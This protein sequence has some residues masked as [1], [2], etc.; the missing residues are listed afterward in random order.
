MSRL[1]R[2]SDDAQTFLEIANDSP[3][4]IRLAGV[5]DAPAS[6]PVEDLGRGPASFAGTESGGR[7]LV[8]DLLPYGVAGIRIGA[9]A[10]AA[11]VGNAL[12][13]RS[14]VDDHAGAIQRAV[15][16]VRASQSRTFRDAGRTGESGFRARGTRRSPVARR[17]CLADKSG[18]AAVPTAHGGRLRACSQGL[19]AGGKDGWCQFDRDRRCESASGPR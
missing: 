13:V 19:A 6:A 7:N 18:S 9:P 17:V 5:L 8:L 12:S 16:A 10:R 4:P 3:Y 1:R 2:M 11:L 14:S 15:D